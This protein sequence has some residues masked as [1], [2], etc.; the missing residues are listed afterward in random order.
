MDSQLMAI[1][2]D[3]ATATPPTPQCRP[4]SAPT[5]TRVAYSPCRTARA[6]TAPAALVQAS[7]ILLLMRNRRLQVKRRKGI[8]TAVHLGP[9][10]TGMNSGATTQRKAL[11]GSEAIATTADALS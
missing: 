2:I 1:A 9:S 6:Y 11:T 8:T 3:T 10:S 5:T 4:M 7:L